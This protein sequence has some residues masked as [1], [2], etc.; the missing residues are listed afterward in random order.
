MD[1]SLLIKKAIRLTSEEL[2]S[3]DNIAN[4]VLDR[5]VIDTIKNYQ[6]KVAVGIEDSAS[7]LM[8][9]FKKRIVD[10]VM[11]RNFGWKSTDDSY[12]MP[13]NCRFSVKKKDCTIFVIENFPQV[14]T[15]SF[16][17]GMQANNIVDGHRGSVERVSLALPYEIFVVVFNKSNFVEL[18]YY[19]TKK[20]LGSLNDM[21][22]ESVLPN[23]HVGGK[24]CL[25]AFRQNGIDFSE[26]CDE[27]IQL[28]WSAKFNTD[29]S[30]NWQQ[31]DKISSMI[32]S[33]NIWEQNSKQN[34]F[35]ILDLPFVPVRS[36]NETL[37]LIESHTNRQDEIENKVIEEVDRIT[38]DLFHKI[39]NYVKKTKFEKFYPKDIKNALICQF[40][41][42]NS[43]I[44]DLVVTLENKL[45][46]MIRDRRP[47]SNLQELQNEPREPKD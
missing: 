47:V 9:T 20:S 29:L 37:K 24:V 25:G 5:I 13:R 7:D 11:T 8:Q 45:D 22:Y 10:Y 18:R 1:S 41:K 17:K 33:G 30:T 31:K 28:F 15:L 3:F 46:I 6:N 23:I 38:S 19:W 27:V 36:L 44:L 32:S 26:I 21:L 39:S 2:S 16:V 43:D 42:N 14:R 34:Q 12:L 40:E 35:F 4:S